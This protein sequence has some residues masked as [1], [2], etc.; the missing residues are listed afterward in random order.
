ME[1]NQ[2]EHQVEISEPTVLKMSHED[3]GMNKDSARWIP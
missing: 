1:K 3:L 2:Q